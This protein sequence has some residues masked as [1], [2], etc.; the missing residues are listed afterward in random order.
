MGAH[1]V[2]SP[3]QKLTTESNQSGPFQAL[4]ETR[5]AVKAAVSSDI[6]H[7]VPARKAA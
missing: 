3:I 1:R 6:A 5:A 2:S 4:C 7:T